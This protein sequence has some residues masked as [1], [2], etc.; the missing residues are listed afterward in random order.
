MDLVKQQALPNNLGQFEHNGG[1]MDYDVDKGNNNELK[2]WLV[3]TDD[4]ESEV[5]GEV[6][7]VMMR[8][9]SDNMLRL[10]VNKERSKAWVTMANNRL[11]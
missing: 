8:R 11:L 2:L 7:K 5:V 10:Q 9:Y 1:N 3:R 6:P 4:G